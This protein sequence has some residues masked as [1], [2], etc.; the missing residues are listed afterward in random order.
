[1]SKY[2]SWVYT[3]TK[4]YI[5][6]KWRCSS[7]TFELS[8][9]LSISLEN[10]DIVDDYYSNNM[11]YNNNV[12]TT[13]TSTFDFETNSTVN[14]ISKQLT[15]K[16]YTMLDMKYVQGYNYDEIGKEFNVTSTT[17]SNRV[18]YIKTKLKNEYDFLLDFND[19]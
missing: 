14:F 15:P 8:G 11:L 6:D 17:V 7:N 1:K 18:N 9:N 12:Y 4:N 5:I 16:D 13:S 3:I 10:N 19:E 2:I